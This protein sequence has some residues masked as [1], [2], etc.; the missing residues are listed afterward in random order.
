MLRKCKTR[1]IIENL[2]KERGFN[3][4]ETQTGDRITSTHG[5]V[6]KQL[7][8]GIG[9]VYCGC[10]ICGKNWKEIIKILKEVTKNR[11]MITQEGTL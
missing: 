9:K 6:G 11:I 3:I 4:I 10:N 8:Y 5:L 2:L 1:T 7:A